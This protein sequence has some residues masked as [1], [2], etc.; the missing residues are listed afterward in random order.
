VTLTF[1]PVGK[2]TLASTVQ[3][4]LQTV[5]ELAG[6]V[7]VTGAQGLGEFLTVLEFFQKSADRFGPFLVETLHD[8]DLSTLAIRDNRD[9]GKVLSAVGKDAATDAKKKLEEAGAVIEMA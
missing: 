9:G 2:G 6:N 8:K 1:T 3:A 4:N 7:T 5:P